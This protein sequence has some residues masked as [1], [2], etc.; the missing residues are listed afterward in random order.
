MLQHNNTLLQFCRTDSVLKAVQQCNEQRTPHSTSICQPSAVCVLASLVKSIHCRL[1][2]LRDCTVGRLHGW[3]LGVGLRCL[4]VLLVSLRRWLRRLLVAWLRG[5]VVA[6]LRGCLVAW[7]RGCVVAWVVGKVELLVLSRE[8]HTRCRSNSSNGSL[9]CETGD[10]N[11]FAVSK[12]E[13]TFIFKT[14][15]TTF[16]YVVLQHNAH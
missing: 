6:W 10:K 2:R 8:A 5:C 15:T 16:F 12:A 4:L 11:S 7:L 3:V 1:R 13:V 9:I 14:K